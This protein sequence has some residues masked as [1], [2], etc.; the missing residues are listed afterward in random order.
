MIYLK[1]HY[2]S[3]VCHTKMRNVYI[4][5]TTQ[6][7]D[8]KAGKQIYPKELRPLW[9]IIKALKFQ[10][11]RHCPHHAFEEKEKEVV[12]TLPPTKLRSHLLNQELKLTIS[13]FS[14]YFRIFVTQF[15]TLLKILALLRSL[16]FAFPLTNSTW[17]WET[18]TMSSS[19]PVVECV[20]GD[21]CDVSATQP[22][23]RFDLFVC[24]AKIK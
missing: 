13:W 11:R 19:A 20:V 22:L 23:Q 7:Y 12:G 2:A 14:T 5:L 17:C 6:I 4:Q 18:Q 21:G 3:D 9:K 10:W 16:F 8:R 24:G 1:G 15:E